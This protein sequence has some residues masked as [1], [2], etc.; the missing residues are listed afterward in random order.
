MEVC[1]HRKKRNVKVLFSGGAPMDRNKEPFK[2]FLGEP[3]TKILLAVLLGV[4][5]IIIVVAIL[6]NGEFYYSNKLDSTNENKEE[7]YIRYPRQFSDDNSIL[8]RE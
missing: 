8:R 4:T 6:R 1:Q 2:N 3:I 5:L 7:Y